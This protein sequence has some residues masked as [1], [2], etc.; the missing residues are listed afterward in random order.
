MIE[1]DNLYS[2]FGCESQ[3]ELY[4]KVKEDKA[5]VR[6][7]RDFI[8]FSKGSIKSRELPL[9]SP[10]IVV[11]FLNEKRLP[12]EHE[13]GIVFLNAKLIPIHTGVFFTNDEKSF[14]SLIK[15]GIDSG[16]V[17][18]FLIHS[19]KNNYGKY[20]DELELMGLDVLDQFHYDK[21]ENRLRSYRDGGYFSLKEPEKPVDLDYK[22]VS[23]D[24]ASFEIGF[25]TSFE[26]MDNFSDFSSLYAMNEV[27]GLNIFDDVI[28][29]QEALKVGYQY[30][31]QEIFGMIMCDSSGMVLSLS[32]LFKGSVNSSVVDPRVYVQKVLGDT[33]IAFTAIF[34]NHPSGDPLTIV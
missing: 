13:C 24:Q 27:I 29:I 20:S 31:Q 12:E 1:K 3:E 8:E 26:N 5:E 22:K 17:N 34:H 14:Y 15:E 18:T 32:E 9:T 25:G 28:D 11:D 7:L 30:E 16:G 21:S 10:D 2:Y 6:S 33:E 19:Q 4:I 23:E